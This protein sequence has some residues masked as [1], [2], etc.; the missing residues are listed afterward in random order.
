MAHLLGRSPLIFNTHA[1]VHKSRIN[2]PVRSFG[3][4]PYDCWFYRA[5]AEFHIRPAY[6]LH[7]FFA[8]AYRF[9]YPINPLL[10]ALPTSCDT[11]AYA[12]YSCFIL[13]G[14]WG[15]VLGWFGGVLRCFWVAWW[16]KTISRCVFAAL[17]KHLKHLETPQ[18]CK[19]QFS[20]C[21]L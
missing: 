8:N 3:R 10:S 14:F 1:L 11:S 18:N 16:F 15:V 13:R 9:A 4:I 2:S 12:D 6:L 17:L 21:S 7:T 20:P 19:K 5:C